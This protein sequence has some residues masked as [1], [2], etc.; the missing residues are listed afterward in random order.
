MS[1]AAVAE[2][3]EEKMGVMVNDVTS[4]GGSMIPKRLPE[5]VQFG[6][7][8]DIRSIIESGF[9]APIYVS[10]LSGNGKTLM[11]D[12]V[13]AV[14][15]RELIAIS[16]TEETDESDLI[17]HYDLINGETV[18]RDGPVIVAMKRGAVLLLD[19]VDQGLFKLMCL[20]N[21]LDNKPVY[22]KKINQIVYPAPGFTVIA[23][24]NTKGRGSDDHKYVGNNVLNE[25]FLE[26]FSFTFEHDYPSKEIE[27]NIIRK[28]FTKY[29]VEESELTNYFA[30][31]LS[32]WSMS[33]RERYKEGAEDLITTRRLDHIVKG[34]SIFKDIKKS[35]KIS[36]S[37]FDT[38]TAKAFMDF[39]D[40]LYDEAKAKKLTAKALGID[41]AG[42]KQEDSPKEAQTANW[43][44]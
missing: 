3:R 40:K 4:S 22:I 5:Y 15:K 17:G 26:R 12:Q 21:V 32:Q 10:G 16:I 35:L 29:G 7:F 30:D 38:S 9:H 18:W 8:Y 42:S 14:T 23:T 27:E 24:A 43:S 33:T 37:R 2:E 36:M 34:Y 1:V 6:C 28:M 31:I 44:W 13:C 41:P 20:Q 39:F 11:T 19:E 25:A